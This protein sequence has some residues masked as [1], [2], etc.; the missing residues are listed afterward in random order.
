LL[1]PGGHARQRQLNFYAF[2]EHATNWWATIG[3]G[4]GL[5]FAIPALVYWVGAA[6]YI[7]CHTHRT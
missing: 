5:S 7:D 3:A 4:V 1:R 6:L 2:A